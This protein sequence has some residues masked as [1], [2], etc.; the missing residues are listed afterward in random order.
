MSD[1]IWERKMRCG[2]CA[3]PW[4]HG[5]RWRT[6]LNP[7]LTASVRSEMIPI[8][9]KISIC[10][11]QFLWYTDIGERASTCATHYGIKLRSLLLFL[12]IVP[13]L[14]VQDRKVDATW[15][16]RYVPGLRGHA[17]SLAFWTCHSK[18]IIG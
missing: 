4:C 16:Q 11:K 10:V 14:L 1:V 8:K 7:Q 17:G 18:P 9:R 2:D 12:L 5:R 3:F 15:L 6:R 13:N